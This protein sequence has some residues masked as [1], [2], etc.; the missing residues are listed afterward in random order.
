MCSTD[1][2]DTS[3]LPP[4]SRQ[5]C[6]ISDRLPL[7]ASMPGITST[8]VR[9]TRSTSLTLSI[10]TPTDALPTDNTMIRLC[11]FESWA[12]R[13]NM[14]RSDT[15]GS[16]RLRRVMTPSTWDSACGTRTMASGTWTISCTSS[17]LIAY[18]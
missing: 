5:I 11:S 16:S 10:I 4:S 2:M 9:A 17:I 15:S 18:S 7:F 12:G 1:R 14:R 13:A 3:R 6:E 8:C